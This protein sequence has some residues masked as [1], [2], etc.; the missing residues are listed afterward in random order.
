VARP[1]WIPVVLAVLAAAGVLAVGAFES[2]EPSTAMATVRLETATAGFDST[3]E[4]ALAGSA[5]TM[6]AATD[7]M[8]ESGIAVTE[9]DLQ[10]RSSVAID[11]GAGA[12][13]IAVT[14]DRSTDALI[15]TALAE[16]YIDIRTQINADERDERARFLAEQISTMTRDLLTAHLTVESARVDERELDRLES[17]V[18]ALEVERDQLELDGVSTTEVERQLDLLRSQLAARQPTV[19]LTELARANATADLLNGQLETLRTEL[20]DVAGPAPAPAELAGVSTIE[21]ESSSSVDGLLLLA[22]VSAATLIGLVVMLVVSQPPVVTVTTPELRLVSNG[23]PT[24]DLSQPRPASERLGTPLFSTAPEAPAVRAVSPQTI[25]MP[26]VQIDDR[27]PEALPTIGSIPAAPVD[28]VHPLTINHP[29]S[30]AGQ[31]YAQLAESLIAQLDGSR[32]PSIAFVG[33]GRATGRTTVAVNVAAAASA[34]GRD[35][36]LVTPLW[37]E[38]DI[39]GLPVLPPGLGITDADEFPPPAEFA[40]ALDDVSSMID[41]VIVDTDP[42]DLQPSVPMLAAQTDLTALVVMTGRSNVAA[43]TQLAE[44]LHSAGARIAGVV[45]NAHEAVV[46]R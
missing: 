7:P 40:D 1:W 45:V 16:A 25:E 30:P 22:A 8:E 31:A 2:G 23:A 12:I 39:P 5:E 41:V 33:P 24:A 4:R 14:G 35:V 18:L 9:A 15:A 38:V 26:V 21:G 32:S 10:I 27:P 44:D 46:A 20:L 19:P 37:D 34:A 43:V 13:T 6:A 28:H 3:S 42:A 29:D 36:L 11:P 17:R